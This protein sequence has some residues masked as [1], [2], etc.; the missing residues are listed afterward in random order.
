MCMKNLNMN[1]VFC[2][3]IAKQDGSNISLGDIVAKRYY[4]STEDAIRKI[5]QFSLAV[6]ITATQSK[7]YRDV[8]PD[9][10]FSFDKKYEVRVRLTETYSGE[11]KDLTSF[12]IDPSVSSDSE[13][14]CRNVFQYTRVC[15]FSNVALTEKREKERFAIKLVIRRCD[16]ENDNWTV[17]SISPIKFENN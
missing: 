8:D 14:L 11:F 12:I 9:L 15:L 1:A 5:S 2:D 17:Q 13:G 7:E 10:V 16:S 4:V 6:F 3:V